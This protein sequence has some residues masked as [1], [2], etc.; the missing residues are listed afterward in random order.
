MSDVVD[1][2]EAL[3]A[4]GPVPGCFMTGLALPL[5]NDQSRRSASWH[6]LISSAR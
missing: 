4:A 5:I 2:N 1:A 3:A 6:F